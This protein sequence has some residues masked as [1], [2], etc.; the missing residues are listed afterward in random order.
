MGWICRGSRWMTGGW[1]T[2]G[3]AREG[4]GGG[5][6]SSGSGVG[7]A[8]ASGVG[9]GAGVSAERCRYTCKA[10]PAGTPAPAERTAQ[11]QGRAPG[12]RV[13]QRET[14][15]DRGPCVARPRVPGPRSAQQRSPETVP[16]CRE[17]LQE[18]D[19][20]VTVAEPP[21]QSETETPAQGQEKVW[22]RWSRGN[23]TRQRRRVRRSGRGER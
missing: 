1:Y 2:S 11:V 3:S 6:G 16:A 12:L 22:R 9:G 5:G 23:P 17:N 13:A 10:A 20:Q 19:R 7:V 15:E 21:G 18:K 4:A 8:G 14:P